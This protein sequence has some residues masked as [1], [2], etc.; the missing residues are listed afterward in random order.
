MITLLFGFSSLLT[1]AKNAREGHP[2][3]GWVKNKAP[4]RLNGP[5]HR[6]DPSG[7]DMLK[8]LQQT[9]FPPLTEIG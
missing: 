5:A 3:V 8:P 1:T 7:K 9:L 4:L 2:S 6:I